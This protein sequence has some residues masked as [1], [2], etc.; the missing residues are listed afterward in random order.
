MT[1]ATT[2]MTRKVI[3]YCES[4]T[5]NVKYGGTKKKSNAATLS[6]D[7][8]ADATRPKRRET[9]TTPSRYTMMMFD[10]SKLGNISQ[11]RRVDDST[12]TSAAAYGSAPP[13][14]GRTR[15]RGAGVGVPWPLMT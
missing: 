4:L 1:S 9:S 3:R 15:R 13:V 6:S 5:A 8:S 12:A 11:A 7:A 2:S 14:G 10:S